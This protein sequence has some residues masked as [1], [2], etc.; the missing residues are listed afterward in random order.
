MDHDSTTQLRQPKILFVYT[1]P[2]QEKQQQEQQQQQC[3]P[4]RDVPGGMPDR[5]SSRAGEMMVEGGRREA[6]PQGCGGGS[7]AGGCPAGRGGDKA[8]GRGETTD[9]GRNPAGV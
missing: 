4:F 1:I 9:A 7:R 2:H 5:R 8:E 6:A 3:G